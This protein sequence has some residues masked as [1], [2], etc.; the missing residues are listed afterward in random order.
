MLAP[1]C[2]ALL[3]REKILDVIA[4]HHLRTHEDVLRHRDDIGGLVVIRDR[5]A[6]QADLLIVVGLE[7]L[8]SHVCLKRRFV[9]DRGVDHALADKV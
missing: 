1:S 2:I 3:L 5:H 7:Q 9:H 4:V 6:R 8:D